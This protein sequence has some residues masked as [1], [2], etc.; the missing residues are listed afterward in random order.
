MRVAELTKKDQKL[1][2]MKAKRLLRKLDNN[3]VDYMG[4]NPCYRPRTHNA[5]CN[6][7]KDVSAAGIPCEAPT[8]EEWELYCAE[9]ELGKVIK[10][11]L[12]IYKPTLENR[13]ADAI[14]GPMSYDDVRVF[15]DELLAYVR[16]V[17]V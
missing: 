14:F 8:A 11:V 17:T 3:E 7:A 1:A 13:T 4:E 2:R 12:T 6:L 10:P 5:A 16:R 9:N 15:K